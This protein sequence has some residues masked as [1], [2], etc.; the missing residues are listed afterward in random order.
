M[1]KMSMEKLIIQVRVNEG[2]M[3]DVS[4]HVPYS[5]EEIARASLD[6]WRAGA[7]MVHYHARMPVTGE[8]SAN[9]EL[10]A[11]VVRRIKQDSDMITFPTLGAM[12]LPTAPERLAHIVEMAKD[13]TTRPDCIPIDM[14][15]INMDRYDLTRRDFAGSG[16]EVYLN[17]V[18]TLRYLCEHSR[19]VG[20]KPVSEMWNVAAV[21]LTEVFLEIGVYDQP[22]LCELPLYGGQFRTFGHSATI[23]GLYS[24]YEVIPP[25]ANWYWMANVL[26]ANAFAVMAAAIELGGHVVVGVADYAYPE[27]GYPTNAELV[28]YVVDLA[29]YSG[30]E[31]ATAAEAREML[32]LA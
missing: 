25:G 17:T 15:S 28:K 32:D 26:G 23:K 24:L 9:V 5:P 20:V 22:L 8:K 13:P 6:C 4:P 2:T 3:R 7:S 31:V 14:L 11:D 29:R 16:D 18:N 27:L 1:A 10:Y 19:E 21:K 30:R 12:L